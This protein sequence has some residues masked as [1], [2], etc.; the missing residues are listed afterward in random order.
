MAV[1]NAMSSGRGNWM[2]ARAGAA[3]IMILQSVSF[4]ILYIGPRHSHL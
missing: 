3:G 2:L 1:P 4:V